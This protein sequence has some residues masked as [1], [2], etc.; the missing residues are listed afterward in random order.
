M[1]DARGKTLETASDNKALN[2]SPAD[3]LDGVRQ[4]SRRKTEHAQARRK[5]L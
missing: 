5:E 3:T 4:A 2:R 1:A